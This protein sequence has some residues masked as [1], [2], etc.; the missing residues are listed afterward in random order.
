MGHFHECMYSLYLF[1]FLFS[2]YDR[3]DLHYFFCTNLSLPSEKESARIATAN[4]VDHEIIFPEITWIRYRSW[5]YNLLDIVPSFKGVI[6]N[7]AKYILTEIL[8]F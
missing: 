8:S 4:A 7:H 1:V 3:A 2:S 6:L 5:L